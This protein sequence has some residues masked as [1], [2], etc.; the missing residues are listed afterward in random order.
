MEPLALSE[1]RT[2]TRRMLPTEAFCELCHTRSRLGTW[3]ASLALVP[4]GGSLKLGCR[5]DVAFCA[6]RLQGGDCSYEVLP[7]TVGVPLL[8]HYHI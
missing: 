7:R 4:F 6:A 3:R 2:S 1:R 5:Y 8:L